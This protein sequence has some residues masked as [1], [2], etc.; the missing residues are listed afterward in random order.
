MHWQIGHIFLFLQLGNLM[1]FIYV[2]WTLIFYMYMRLLEKDFYGE[3]FI[4]MFSWNKSY[5]PFKRKWKCIPII[6]LPQ[7]E[8]KWHETVFKFQSS[9]KAFVITRKLKI[10][11]AFYLKINTCMILRWTATFNC[12]VMIMIH[13][14]TI[15]LYKRISDAAK[16]KKKNNVN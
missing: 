6:F 15:K 12:P 11:Y 16:N 3:S 13:T 14:L 7:V 1:H 2:E 5:L 8:E 9:L 4:K 10:Y